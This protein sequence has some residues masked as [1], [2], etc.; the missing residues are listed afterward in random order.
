MTGSRS[1]GRLFNHIDMR[2]QVISEARLMVRSILAVFLGL[3]LSNLTIFGLEYVVHAV[4]PPPAGLD[5]G[6]P[7]FTRRHRQNT[8]RRIRVVAAGVG[9]R[10]GPWR[11]AGRHHRATSTDS[12][13]IN[14]GRTHHGRRDHDHASYPAPGLALDPRRWCRFRQPLI[15]ARGSQVDTRQ[16][17]LGA[18]VR[19]RRESLR[20]AVNGPAK[21][22][23]SPRTRNPAGRVLPNRPR[24]VRTDHVT[25]HAPSV[26]ETG[27]SPHLTDFYGADWHSRVLCHTV[28]Q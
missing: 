21:K 8:D 11:M 24:S 17:G 12:S 20:R 6:D 3:V 13:R 26:D 28:I 22:N 23:R 5:A 7:R 1:S 25:P 15:R 18:S 2:T 16:P 27:R 10:N 4:Y 19:Q 14:C 9:L